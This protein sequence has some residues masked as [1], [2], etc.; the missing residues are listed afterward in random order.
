M[1]PFFDPFFDSFH[2]SLPP[3]WR[4]SYHIKFYWGR[5]TLF[6]GIFFNVWITT[7]RA[8]KYITYTLDPFK[9]LF[10]VPLFF[11]G[12][13][14]YTNNSLSLAKVNLN[15]CFY[16]VFDTK[17]NWVLWAI[18]SFLTL[19]RLFA[20]KWVSWKRSANSRLDVVFHQLISFS[21]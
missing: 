10:Q 11:K 5:T 8:I 7:E 20:Y 9:Y 3:I 6:A 14:I 4:H 16:L 12:R 18:K 15:A 17:A 1:G 19:C 2:Y 13:T 21:H